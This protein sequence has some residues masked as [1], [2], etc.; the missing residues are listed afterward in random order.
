MTEAWRPPEG[1]PSW[2]VLR[3]RVGLEVPCN[4]EPEWAG[5]SHMGHQP[6]TNAL[7]SG[8][9]HMDWT[10]VSETWVDCGG[11]ELVLVTL[12]GSGVQPDLPADQQQWLTKAYR[13]WRS[14]GAPQTSP[15]QGKSPKA[16][17]QVEFEKPTGKNTLYRVLS[18][19]H[20][21][22]ESCLCQ[23]WGH[24]QEGRNPK[25]KTS[26]HEFVRLPREADKWLASYTEKKV[27]PA[28][29]GAACHRKLLQ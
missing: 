5:M 17:S 27:C 11:E 29:T 22:Q 20:I 24:G 12:K 28:D 15:P 21:Y 3:D 23:M 4:E 10:M 6:R 14:G 2:A 18:S 7:P 9:W 25:T 1:C 26:A 8:P 19:R 16:R 13:A